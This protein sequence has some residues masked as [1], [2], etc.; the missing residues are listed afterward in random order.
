MLPSI[1]CTLA[2]VAV[3][4]ADLYELIV[5]FV[6]DSTFN[7]PIFDDLGAPFSCWMLLPELVQTLF[8]HTLQ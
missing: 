1:I 2:L 7:A 6:L 5:V 8:L 3:A 4:M